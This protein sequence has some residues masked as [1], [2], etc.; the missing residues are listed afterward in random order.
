MGFPG[1]KIGECDICGAILTHSS[2]WGKSGSG[3]SNMGSP[4]ASYLYVMKGSRDLLWKFWDPS[5]SRE[6]L[7]LETSNLADILSTRCPNDKNAN[8]GQMRS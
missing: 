4:A 3:N 1:D 2:F 7:E 5:I 8:L 6:R